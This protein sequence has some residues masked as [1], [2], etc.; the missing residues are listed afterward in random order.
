MQEKLKCLA[1]HLSD[2][3]T[4]VQLWFTFGSSL[5]KICQCIAFYDSVQKCDINSRLQKEA[6]KDSWLLKYDPLPLRR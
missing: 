2:A 3:H 6:M 5:Y 4:Q 1:S